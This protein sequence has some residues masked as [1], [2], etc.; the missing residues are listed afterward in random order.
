MCF[1]CTLKR[2]M[3]PCL[4]LYMKNNTTSFMCI[5][6]CIYPFLEYNNIRLFYFHSKKLLGFSAIIT[7]MI[8]MIKCCSISRFIDLCVKGGCV[9]GGVYGRLSR[10]LSFYKHFFPFSDFE[11]IMLLNLV[12]E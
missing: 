1:V 9:G 4:C 8:I 3:E 2:L 5:T 7:I 11:V 10:Y 12:K 6:K